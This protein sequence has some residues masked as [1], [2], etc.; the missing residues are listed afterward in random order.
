MKT[1]ICLCSF[2]I[3]TLMIS[4][5]PKEDIKLEKSISEKIEST[6]KDIE[7]AMEYNYSKVNLAIPECRILT[8]NLETSYDV[9]EQITF[10]YDELNRLIK[11]AFYSDENLRRSNIFEYENQNLVK[12]FLREVH[13][14]SY[15]FSDGLL[16]E[17]NLLADGVIGERTIWY[18]SNQLPN[19]MVIVNHKEEITVFNLV[20]D[21]YGNII[22]TELILQN[23]QTPVDAFRTEN[24][25]DTNFNPYFN[26]LGFEDSDYF[27]SPNNRIEQKVF[28]NGVPQ[29]VNESVT[30]QYDSNNFLLTKEENSGSTHSFEYVY[31][32]D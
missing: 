4:C 8:Q 14:A 22:E 13:D 9:S 12:E 1:L 5:S 10:E 32:C 3:I 2:T 27:F 6:L 20:A 30:F 28:K 16:K 11:K 21:Q 24:K 25:F 29:K 23:N 26:L 19:R 18:Y 15:I 7:P 31:E 17:I